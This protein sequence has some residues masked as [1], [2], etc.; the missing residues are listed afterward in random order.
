MGFHHL[1][2]DKKYV[3]TYGWGKIVSYLKKQMD[4]W[5]IQKLSENGY[6]DFKT[7]YMPVIMNI[8]PEG[9]NNNDL[10]AHARVTKQAM[11][12]V[13]KE[14]QSKGYV[15]AKVDPN[16][17][18]STIFILTG[19]G[20]DFVKCARASVSGLM[21]DYRKEFGKKNFEE[22]LDQLVKVIEYNEK[23]LND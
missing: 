16:D 10:A 6:K 14:L 1:L 23:K 22:L 11:S 17:K 19:R 7:A 21:D 2:H 12:K 18:R 3:Q 4:Q 15:S 9:T 13:V 5:S 20:K 8:A